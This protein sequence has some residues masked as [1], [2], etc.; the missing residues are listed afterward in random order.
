[1]TYIIGDDPSISNHEIFLELITTQVPVDNHL[2]VVWSPFTNFTIPS[3]QNMKTL[4]YTGGKYINGVYSKL[5]NINFQV[6]QLEMLASLAREF[7]RERV[8][9]CVLVYNHSDLPH[10]VRDDWLTRGI[11]DHISH[12]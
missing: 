12:S 8:N 1:M 10:G 7:V 4:Q 6:A 5:E 3:M 9:P 2:S 11:M